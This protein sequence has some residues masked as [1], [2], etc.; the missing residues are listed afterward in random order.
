MKF[1]W[2][3]K[4]ANCLFKVEQKMRISQNRSLDKVL[5]L[6]GVGGLAAV[7]CFLSFL[8]IGLP[9]S[10]LFV[11]IYLSECKIVKFC[12][13]DAELSNN[14]LDFNGYSENYR[15]RI[16]MRRISDRFFAL[17]TTE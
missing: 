9:F 17:H 16:Q 7:G 11:F 14:Q 1:L 12:W 5:F 8:C 4:I 15:S 6:S 13:K 2:I 3:L 10:Y